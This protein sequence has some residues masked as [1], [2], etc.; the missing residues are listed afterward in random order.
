MAEELLKPLQNAERHLLYPLI[1][2]IFIAAGTSFVGVR[3]MLPETGWKREVGAFLIA[4]GVFCSVYTL[5][6][7]QRHV[8]TELAARRIS[9]LVLICHFAATLLLGL[10]STPSSYV[11]LTFQQA[12]I[13]FMEETYKQA[14]TSKNELEGYIHAFNGAK[15][16]L[17]V[18]ARDAYEEAEREI[19][20]GSSTALP[21]GKGPLHLRNLEFAIGMDSLVEL[22]QHNID[23]ANN[24]MEEVETSIRRL[25]KVIDSE[26]T[27]EQKTSDF[28]KFHRSFPARFI[29]VSSVDLTGQVEQKIEE[30]KRSNITPS[31][32]KNSQRALRE[33][34]NQINR[35]LTDVA[36]R[37]DEKLVQINPIDVYSAPSPANASFRYLGSFWIQFFI[38]FSFDAA[39]IICIYLRLA[40]LIEIHRRDAP[41][42]DRSISLRQISFIADALKEI[43]NI[44]ELEKAKD[45][46][47]D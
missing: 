22:I 10:V 33:L 13:L 44:R 47:I 17:E 29:Q 39:A 35:T 1:V 26:D 23:I 5:I 20:G 45:K 4:L 38:A 40:V 2:L 37:L 9:S 19:S 42:E 32:D 25:R 43:T 16:Q 34:N 12:Q 11:A 28:E 8:F 24:T 3:A 7:I 31:N 41:P 30:L 21:K 27:L 6:H 18:V 46:E 14:Q 15:Q 36:M